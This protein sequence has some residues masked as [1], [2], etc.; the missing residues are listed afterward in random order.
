MLHDSAVPGMYPLESLG[1]G[2]GIV[3]PS[4][5]LIRMWCSGTPVT[6]CGS[7]PWGSEPFP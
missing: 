2:F 7:M 1:L 3:K 5:K 4:H 6:I